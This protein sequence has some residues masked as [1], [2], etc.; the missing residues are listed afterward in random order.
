[1]IEVTLLIKRA[2]DRQKRKRFEI[3]EIQELTKAHVSPHEL[4]IALKELED[5][6]EVSKSNQGGKVVYEL[7]G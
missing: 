5:Q 3:S 4:S 2:E 6:A 1:M 7:T